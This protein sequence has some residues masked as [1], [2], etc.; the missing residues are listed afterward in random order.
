MSRWSLLAIPIIAATFGCVPFPA[1]PEA[2]A[3]LDAAVAQAVTSLKAAFPQLEAELVDAPG[4]AVF[5]RVTKGGAGLGGAYGIGELFEGGQFKGFCDVAQGTIGAQI[6]GQ[7]YREL[8]VF[9]RS[10]SLERFKVAHVVLAMQT[11]GVGGHTGVGIA[12]PY[13]DGVEIYLQPIGGLMGEA[14]IGAQQFSFVPEE[15]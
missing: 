5:P 15:G 13:E 11:S 3:N 1:T 12:H 6:G 8:V 4:Y 10:E 9:K 7:V 2:R 14:S